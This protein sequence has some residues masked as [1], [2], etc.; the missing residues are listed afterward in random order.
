M[1]LSTR[2]VERQTRIAQ[3]W[4][5]VNCRNSLE[6]I[7]FLQLRPN[8]GLPCLGR[9]VGSLSQA[10]SKTQINHRTQRSV[11]GELGQPVTGTDK[12]GCWKLHT[13]TE[14]MHKSWRWTIWEHKVTVKHQTKCSL[15]CFSYAVFFRQSVFNCNKLQQQFFSIVKWT[16]ETV[17]RFSTNAH[18]KNV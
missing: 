3:A 8:H 2:A 4:L 15:C 11:T 17:K 14:V 5:Q 13:M 16:T 1:P 9:N 10:P 12:Q 18:W 6:T 7:S